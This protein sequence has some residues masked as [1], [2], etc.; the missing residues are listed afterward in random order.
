MPDLIKIIDWFR[1]PVHQLN[2]FNPVW[3][4][5]ALVESAFKNSGLVNSRGHGTAMEGLD[6][7]L[8]SI[9]NQDSLHLIG[10]ITLYTLIKRSIRNR[11]R[12]LH[13]KENN[14]DKDFRFNPPIFITGLS[15]SGT[16][17]LHR[18]LSTNPELYAFPLWELFDP[19][20]RSGTRDVRRLKTKFEI[21][22]KNILLPDLD[23][24]HY[25][26]ANNTEECIML[27]ANSFNS[28]LFIDI[29]PLPEYLEWIIG[30]DRYETYQEYYDQL[31]ILQSFH[32]D[33]RFILKA[34]N[35]LGN[36]NELIKYIP[37]ATVIQMHRSPLE[38][39]NSLASLRQTLHRIVIREV[40]IHETKNQIIRLFENEI[41]RN[42]EF[43]E[44]FPDRVLSLSYKKLVS[45]PIGS[46]KEI[47]TKAAIPWTDTLKDISTYYVDDLKSHS[48]RHNYKQENLDKPMP[49]SIVKYEAHFKDFL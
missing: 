10:E 34:P 7:L 22:V 18:L 44:S 16:T 43:H 46:L 4:K 14:L 47:Y 30:A 28:Q 19:F 13:I 41:A 23:K 3:E 27:L 9:R 17:F 20:T 1:N 49:D 15:R 33:K 31:R 38:C 2:I 12:Y 35:H 8:L 29:A 42:L 6:T 25:T 26:R 37:E 40:N 45:D 32:P 5:E 21:N 39:I 11:S 24:K 36:L 48:G